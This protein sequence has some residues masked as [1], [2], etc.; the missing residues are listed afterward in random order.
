MQGQT[1]RNVDDKKCVALPRIY[2]PNG[3]RYQFTD[4]ACLAKGSALCIVTPQSIITINNNKQMRFADRASFD[5]TLIG[6]SKD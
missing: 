2:C 5:L 1:A 3:G 6:I 4:S